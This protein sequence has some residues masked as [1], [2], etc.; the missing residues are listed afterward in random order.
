MSRFACVTRAYVARVE[1]HPGLVGQDVDEVH[2]AG[3][4]CHGQQVAVWVE[5]HDCQFEALVDL[6]VDQFF[7]VSRAYLFQVEHEPA[8]VCFQ[9]E[10]QA[11]DRVR[12]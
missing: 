3:R 2:L 9:P 6:L 1:G 4:V 8:P 5:G 7:L 10:H 11:A 12:H